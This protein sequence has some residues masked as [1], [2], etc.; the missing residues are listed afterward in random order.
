MNNE[1]EFNKQNGLWWAKFEDRQQIH[2]EYHTRH[3]KDLDYS[4]KTSKKGTCVQAGG[5]VGIWAL[6]LKDYYK[7]VLSFEADPALAECMIK[8]TEKYSNIKCFNTA[9]SDKNEDIVFYRT[10]KSGTGFTSKDK[11][12]N[13]ENCIIKSITIDSL[14]LNN[15]DVLFLDVE[16]FEPFVLRGA[17]ETIK[18]FKPLIHIELLEKSSQEI[19]DILTSL[20]Y[21]LIKKYGK[22]GIFI[23][24]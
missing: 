23:S 20:N 2:Y 8:N 14:N 6:K 17:Q 5:N 21:K 3:L 9:L 10:G 1:I 12:T 7:E 16:G 22:D 18:K 19:I 15:C 11:H 4:I 13:K 24:G